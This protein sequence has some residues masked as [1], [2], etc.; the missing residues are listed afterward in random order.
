M[1]DMRTAF[2]QEVESLTWIDNTT[3]RGVF[4]K[5]LYNFDF[6]IYLCS[7]FV[8]CLSSV[9]YVSFWFFTNL[10]WFDLCYFQEKAM[11]EKIGYP[12]LCKNIT[13]LEKY[14]SGVRIFD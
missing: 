8:L 7:Q 6:V 12:K 9:C 11:I 1:D 5:V 10:F 4:E 2:R 3:R 14:Y 13:L